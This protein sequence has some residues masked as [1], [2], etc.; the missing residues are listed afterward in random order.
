M[1]CGHWKVYLR[2][3]GETAMTMLFLL[4]SAITYVE[5]TSSELSVWRPLVQAS[6]GMR[7][8]IAAVLG[9]VLV[10]LVFA[11]SVRATSGPTSPVSGTSGEL[12]AGGADAGLQ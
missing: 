2:I 11:A 6:G 12:A 4:L 5:R 9:V 1:A 3:D 10:V 7:R 8:R